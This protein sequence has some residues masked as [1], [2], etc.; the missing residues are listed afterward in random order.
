[1]Q[2]MSG[3]KLSKKWDHM[4][5]LRC[6][7]MVGN[8]RFKSIGGSAFHSVITLLKYEWLERWEWEDCWI[9]FSE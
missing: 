5:F 6:V 1:M 8:D 7:L 2:D 3:L 9:S 4:N